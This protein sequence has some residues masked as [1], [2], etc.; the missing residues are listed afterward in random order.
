MNI[1]LEQSKDY[2]E[3]ENLTREAFWNVYRPGCVEH[4]V[5][6]QYRNRPDFIPELD[7]VLEEDGRIIGHVMYS[8]AEIVCE[9]G[10]TYPAWTFGP[11]SIHPDYKR[12]GYGLQLLKH[13]LEKAKEMGIGLLCM[14]GN[15]DFYRHA[16]FV[17][18]SSLKIH[19]HGEPKESEVPYF[20]AQE[21]IPGYWG[22]REGTYHTPEGYFAA[23]EQPEAFAAYDATFPAKEKHLQPGQLPQFCQS[24]GM[25][26][27]DDGM[28]GHRADGSIHFDYCQYCYKD[29]AFT[30][31]CT[32]DEQQTI[33]PGT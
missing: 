32:M 14:E 3:V 5:L 26:L 17:L 19:Y 23:D 28:C 20:L 29:G 15:I 10:S 22:N 21:L 12:K 6:R 13:S 1:R 25:P 24:C 9:D 11:I 27:T 30:N 31:D 16:G 2:R 8:K 18:A 7:F 4:Y 33:L